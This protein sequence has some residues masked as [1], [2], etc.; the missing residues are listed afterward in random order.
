LL[1]LST[2]LDPPSYK[3]F[4]Q[5]SRSRLRIKNGRR[6]LGLGRSDLK[7][8]EE[9]PNKVGLLGPRD[10]SKLLLLDLSGVVAYERILKE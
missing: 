10:S 8:S 1:P 9:Y 2:Q 7:W 6:R 4:L 5:F 3:S